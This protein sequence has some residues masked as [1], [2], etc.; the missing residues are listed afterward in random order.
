VDAASAQRIG[1]NSSGRDEMRPG[2]GLNG[3]MDRRRVSRR[4]GRRLPPRVRRIATC[5]AIGAVLLVGWVVYLGSALP[6]QSVVEHWNVAWVGFD[7]LVVVALTFTAVLAWRRDRHVVMP[8]IAT[9]TLLVA[10]AWMDVTMSSG[11]DLVASI[12]LAVCVE[13][14]LAGVSVLVAAAALGDLSRN[15]SPRPRVA[16]APRAVGD[17]LNERE[18]RSA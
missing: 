6:Q 2:R 8:A 14:P 18:I 16:V 1:R 13:L 17:R 10:D 4:S 12:V 3:G 11:R 9:A 5:Y 15:R 7:V